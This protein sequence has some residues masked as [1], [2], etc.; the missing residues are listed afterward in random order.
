MKV[1]AISFE[2]KEYLSLVKARGA[3]SNA[4]FIPS[5]L[6]W[7]LPINLR[8][9]MFHGESVYWDLKLQISPIQLPELVNVRIASTVK[10]LNRCMYVTLPEVRINGLGFIEF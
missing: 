2:E 8:L 6:N 10:K 1:H 4:C 9:N 7:E 3:D 5:R